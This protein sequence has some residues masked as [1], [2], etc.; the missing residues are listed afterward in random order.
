MGLA[1]I[2]S[3]LKPS[4]DTQII[5][6]KCPAL[7]MKYIFPKGYIAIDGASLTVVETTEST[8]SVHL[9][10]QTL[11]KTHFG[12]KKAG[13]FVNIEIDSN[14][15]AIITTVDRWMEHR[16]EQKNN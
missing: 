13:D 3:V 8:F 2:V 12:L 14:T 9:I 5:T 1:E 10:P 6:F 4:S 11:E 15:Q 7:L 16:Y